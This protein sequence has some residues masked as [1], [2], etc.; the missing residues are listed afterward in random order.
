MNSLLIILKQ[1]KNLIQIERDD[2]TIKVLKQLLLKDPYYHTAYSL[3]AEAYDRQGLIKEAYNTLKQGLEYDE[4]NKELYYHLGI[5]L[6]KLNRLDESESMFQEAIALDPDYK[7]AILSLIA[8]WK[9]DNK[10]EL[11]VDLI[12]DIKNIGSVDPL[13]EW[14]L[15][16]A[17]NELDERKQ[18]LN[19]YKQAYTNLQDDPEFLKEYGMF[20]YEEGE[21]QEAVNIFRTYL[22]MI[23]DDYD[24]IAFTERID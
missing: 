1:L 2:V 14:E 9:D 24:I 8:Q 17:Y 5:L 4:F 21:H 19:A 12:H 10:N 13:Y 20:L 7:E 11:I 6:Q 16:R 15:G 23:P 18:A 22:V 3:L